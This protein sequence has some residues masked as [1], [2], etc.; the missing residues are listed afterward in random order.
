MIAGFLTDVLVVI[1]VL[2]V[3]IFVHELGHFLAAKGFGVHVLTFS[4]GFGKR[5]F[6]FYRGRTDYCVRVLPFGG[7]VK[8]AGDDPTEVHGGDPGEFLSRPRWQRFVIVIMG[9]TMNVMLAIIVLTGLYRFHH[10]KWA[11]EEQPVKIGAIDPG[12]PAA[13]AGLEVGDVVTRFD[14]LQHPK[15]EDVEVKVLTDVGEKVPLALERGNK[16]IDTS[17]TPEAQGPDRVGNAGWYPIMPAVVDTVD[18]GMPASKA[19]LKPGD[20]IVAVNGRKLLFSQLVVD[21]LQ[22]SQGKPVNL[23]IR[24]AG[25][26]FHVQTSAVYSQVAGTKMWRIGITIRNPDYI[27]RRLPLGAALRDSVRDNFRSVLVTFDVLGKILTKKMSP[28]SLSGPIGIAQI[29]GEAYRRGF[30]D[31]LMIVA[32]ISLQ[33]GIFNLLPIPILDGG[34]I[35][36]LVI[37]GLMRRDLSLRFKERFVQVG[38]VFLLILAVFV[39]YNDIM[40]TLRIS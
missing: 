17:L 26:D 31:L 24:R 2:G 18:P 27:I 28:R 9:P 1:V 8:M 12:S 25:T 5:L 14:G 11:Y 7:Y 40:K 13:M 33:L 6:G 35:L 30:S 19:G 32:F 22:A 10:Q 3:M 16:L 20:E 4:L 15:W 37:E 36:L 23:T 21:A 39:V 29:S 38:I 34:V